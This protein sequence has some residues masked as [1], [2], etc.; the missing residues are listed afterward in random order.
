MKRSVYVLTALFAG[1]ALGV[2]AAGLRN[3]TGVADE[4]G[5]ELPRMLLTSE[6]ASHA[7]PELSDAE[8]HDATIAD[9]QSL[10]RLIEE[11]ERAALER[12]A[13]AARH[14][15]LQT[16]IERLQ[17]RLALTTAVDAETPPSMSIESDANADPTTV[18]SS[19]TEDSEVQ[20]LLAAGLDPYEVAE[21]R[22]RSG[23]AE[24]DRLYLRDRAIREGWFGDER[25]REALENLEDPQSALRTRLGEQAFDR[26]LHASGDNNRIRVQS[27]IEASP[28]A[29]AGLESGD[30]IHRYANQRI[31][32]M[33]DLR[34][35]MA[36]GN[37]GE[38]VSVEVSR[39]GSRRSFY[40]S[41]GPL[42]VRLS[43]ARVEP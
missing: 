42:G 5:S 37:A 32:S 24:M 28:A 13:L 30:I 27:I 23:E 40:L 39:D 12:R 35:A 18:A 17:Q 11:V 20:A 8:V 29:A 1:V 22:R 31:F 16:Q 14:D 19:E 6:V 7:T 33:A 15:D 21:I 34:S 3:P 9:T 26:Y 38:S 10:V 36:D 25:Y 43:P 41:R 4:V 2:L